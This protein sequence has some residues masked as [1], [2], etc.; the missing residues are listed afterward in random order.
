MRRG[1]EI[2][3]SACMTNYGL[4]AAGRLTRSVA[5]TTATM[6]AIACIVE[7]SDASKKAAADSAAASAAAGGTDSGGVQAIEISAPGYNVYSL[8]TAGLGAQMDSLPPLSSDPA[9]TQITAQSV[10]APPESSRWA[11]QTGAP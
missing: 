1:L 7:E 6:L 2:E 9:F 10:V 4:R 3:L 8:D 5:V 11:F